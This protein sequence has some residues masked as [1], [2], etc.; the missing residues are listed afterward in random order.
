MNWYKL[1]LDSQL[2]DSL[3]NY[4]YVINL[5]TLKIKAYYYYN[6]YKESLSFS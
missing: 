4:F 6:K 2:L 3:F 1:Y 5:S